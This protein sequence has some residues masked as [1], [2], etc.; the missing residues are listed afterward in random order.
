M[1]NICIPKNVVWGIYWLSF[2]ATSFLIV[3]DNC[4]ESFQG[5]I[6][7]PD[8]NNSSLVGFQ[9]KYHS[10]NNLLGGYINKNS[11][12][13]S[14]PNQLYSFVKKISL[15]Q[16]ENFSL[17]NISEEN[18]EQEFND[19]WSAEAVSDR[20]VEMAR[21]LSGGDQSK[22]DVLRQSILKGFE[23]AKSLLGKLPEISQNT[24][25]LTL[26]KFDEAF[27]VQEDSGFLA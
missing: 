25:E 19:Y 5:G 2:R 16:A 24:Y 20:I 26:K 21:S 11:Q 1:K 12:D 27:K 18:F 14:Y 13:I 10:V 9:E 4:Y 23:E 22:A 6:V 17:K 8:I 7:M 15:E 3:T